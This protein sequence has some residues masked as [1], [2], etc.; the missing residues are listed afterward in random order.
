MIEG[1]GLG[2][3]LS[4]GLS[5]GLKPLVSVNLSDTGVIAGMSGRGYTLAAAIS[6]G[7]SLSDLPGD[8]SEGRERHAFKQG[9]KGPA[10]HGVS[11]ES[12]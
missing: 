1:K 6:T 12:R 11:G 3:G 7:K 9:R 8:I 10:D 5:K 2:K 4:K